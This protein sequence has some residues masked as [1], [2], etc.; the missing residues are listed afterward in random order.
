MYK[1]EKFWSQILPLP[2]NLHPLTVKIPSLK[3]SLNPSVVKSYNSHPTRNLH[4]LNPF[5][6]T[7]LV[8]FNSRIPHL[9]N[10]PHLPTVKSPYSYTTC[11][12]Q[13]SYPRTCRQLAFFNSLISKLLP[14][15]YPLSVKSAYSHP[16]PS[17]PIC[18]FTVQLSCCNIVTG[19]CDW[20]FMSRLTGLQTNLDW[21]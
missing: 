20:K 11:I 21:S 4:W 18:D 15:P 6:P 16:A 13:Q 8:S 12:L 9:L 2:S 19:S 17:L 14:S 3:S 7:Q 10:I 1:D 5:S